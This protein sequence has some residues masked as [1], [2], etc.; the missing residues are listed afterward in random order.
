MRLSDVPG[1]S[2]VRV[3]LVW[4]PPWNMANLSD[5]VRLQLGLL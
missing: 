1:V 4:D 5:E 3:E 2:D